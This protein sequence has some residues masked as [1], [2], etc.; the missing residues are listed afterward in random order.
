[1]IKPIALYLPQFHPIEEND[2]WWG[3]GFTEWHNVARAKQ[4]FKD[5]YQPHLPADL[6][7]Y[8]LRLRETRIAQAAMAR[9]HG[10]YGFCYYH[11]WFNGKRLLN[12][13]LD[14]LLES[15]QP[16]LPF[17]LCW[18]NENWTR[19]WD[20]Q[21]KE[22]LIKQDY[23]EADDLAHIRFLLENVFCDKRYIKVDGKPFFIF[24]R[25][26]HFNDFKN[27]ILVWR[28]EAERT[29]FPGLYLGYMQ[30]FA[31]KEAPEVIGLD[32]AVAFH[33]DVAEMPKHIHPNAWQKILH[34]TRLFHS[35]H[36]QHAVF[37][38]ADYVAN[39][40][41]KHSIKDNLYQM[42]FPM[43]DNSARRKMNA[44]IFKDAAPALYKSWLQ[45]TLQSS[46]SM[47]Q[48]FV[49]INAWNEWAEGC[50]L[51]PCQKWGTQ[52]LEA[53]KQAI[54]ACSFDRKQPFIATPF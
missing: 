39:M 1:M 6:G 47:G 50:H 7:F 5:H 25:P 8:D 16:D 38:Y 13:P 43:W 22:V 12:R 2:H 52:Y 9:E 29:G 10:I 31:Y 11:Y 20:G 30:S 21:E 54:E 48:N 33:P 44:V 15:D 32:C 42:V 46:K 3:H 37:R 35:Y 41:K 51:E 14:D 45:H 36:Y 23:S 24:Y 28:R 18:A 19:T 53:T 34:H 40:L 4:Q 17:M 26:Q 27:T 49:F